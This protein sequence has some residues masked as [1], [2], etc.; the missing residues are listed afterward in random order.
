MTFGVVPADQP[1]HLFKR[2]VF[3]LGPGVEDPG[4]FPVIPDVYGL[5]VFDQYYLSPGTE[6]LFIDL[7]DHIPLALVPG[8]GRVFIK[9]ENAH[10]SF[11]QGCF[12]IPGMKNNG[13]YRI[14]KQGTSDYLFAIT[15]MIGF[16]N[17]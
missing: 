7:P 8:R 15:A 13:T 16:E 3:I 17:A 12:L 10:P 1:R 6:V 4:M 2:L 5:R 11:P 9:P 14:R